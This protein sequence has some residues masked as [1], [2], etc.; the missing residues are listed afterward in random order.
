MKEST[1]LRKESFILHAAAG[2]MQ[3]KGLTN[4][5]M[6]E[7]AEKANITKVT[8][9]SYFESKENLT[10]AVCYDVHTK[11]SHVVKAVIENN[12][13]QNGLESCISIKSAMLHFFLENPF[14][15]R[16]M[17]EFLS[18]F[19]MPDNKLSD[20]M[21]SSSYRLKL[22][23]NSVGLGGM[24]NAELERGRRDGSIQSETQGIILFIYVMN[25]I[26]GYL[27][28]V[29]MPGFKDDNTAEFL[30]ELTDYH[31]LVARTMLTTPV[32]ATV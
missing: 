15:A 11:M 32:H 10:M 28:M 24:L 27:T 1:R 5:T 19:N 23:E 17:H 31:E 16:M 9:Y 26:A 12:T 3:K 6:E 30:E 25:C 7:V 29:S 18:I 4:F 2:V 8:L 14:R 22:N 20:A 21:K 13:D